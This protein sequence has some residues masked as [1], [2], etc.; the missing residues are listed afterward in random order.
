VSRRRWIR[1]RGKEEE[2]KS[3][4]DVRRRRRRGGEGRE[5]DLYCHCVYFFFVGMIDI[6]RD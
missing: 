2:R 1:G 5:G 6:D 4:V 3:V